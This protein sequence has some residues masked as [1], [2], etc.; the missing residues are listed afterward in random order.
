MRLRF[1]MHKLP[2]GAGMLT[3]GFT[4]L[5]S[6]CHSG[7][8][9]EATGPQ[10]TDAP[11]LTAACL[12]VAKNTA[13]HLKATTGVQ[14]TVPKYGNQPIATGSQQ[15]NNTIDVIG[16][17]FAVATP[18]EIAGGPNVPQDDVDV[19]IV[20]GGKFTGPIAQQAQQC[21]GQSV[22]TTSAGLR[23]RDCTSSPQ[24]EGD[25]WSNGEAVLVDAGS[26]ASW[27]AYTHLSDGAPDRQ[28]VRQ[29]MDG[30]AAAL[31]WLNGVRFSG[32]LPSA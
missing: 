7:S 23:Y 13:D 29:G 19:A 28:Q 30:K 9:I 2:L 24:V 16:C 27:L 11:G 17:T 5:L 4:L 21:A 6:G 1:R 31:D 3:A 32:K 25:S 8:G 20:G 15:V 12:Q 14:Y 18:A 10:V 22:G 26:P